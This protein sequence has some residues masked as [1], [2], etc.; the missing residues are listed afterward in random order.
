MLNIPLVASV[1]LGGCQREID[2]GLLA[3]C[4]PYSFLIGSSAAQRDKLARLSRPSSVA[5]TTDQLYVADT[6]NDR[7]L[8]FALPTSTGAAAQQVLMVSKPRSVAVTADG[9]FVLVGSGSG[10][11]VWDRSS[12][13]SDI[14]IATLVGAV[15][16]ES[17]NQPAASTAAGLVFI[18][19]S[20]NHRVFT[21]DSSDLPGLPHTITARLRMSRLGQRDVNGLTAN[22]GRGPGK[23]DANGFDNPTS[24]I[25]DTTLPG[26]LLYV[27]DTGNHRVGTYDLRGDADRDARVQIIKDEKNMELLQ[28]PRAL[29]VGGGALGFVDGSRVLLFS[30]PPLVAGRTRLLQAADAQVGGTSA[31]GPDPFTL[32]EPKGLAM[33]GSMLAVA[34]TDN[35]RV[36]LWS[37]WQERLPMPGAA[38]VALGQP[39]FDT[40]VPNNLG[41]QTRGLSAPQGL[42]GNGTVLVVCDTGNSRVLLYNPLP[43]QGPGPE[44]FLVLGQ[45]SAAAAQVPTTPNEITLA[46]PRGAF[47]GDESLLVA[48]TGNHRVLSF[49]DINGL[50]DT[51]RKAASGVLGQS[52]LRS[53]SAPT[54]PSAT[55]LH[56]PHG[57][58]HDGRSIYVAD[59]GHNRVLRFAGTVPGD[60][61]ET[62]NLVLGQPDFVS[63]TKVSVASS[64]SLSAPEAVAVSPGGALLVADTGN[65]RVLIW[66]NAASLSSG[67]SANAELPSPEAR[68][69]LSLELPN[70]IAFGADQA[71]YLADAGN[72]RVLRW[73]SLDAALAGAAPKVLDS[74]AT[75][76]SQP[77]FTDGS[78][79]QGLFVSARFLYVSDGINHRIAGIALPLR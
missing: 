11:V 34:D 76:F 28:T 26:S 39:G 57:V 10:V 61:G 72:H 7:V 17:F 4:E 60:K 13:R 38:Q 1:A 52:D 23:V 9:R 77:V 22:A 40:N 2:C 50:G 66:Y 32:R 47:L 79:P 41:N 42:T 18:V 78:V 74:R 21:F 68:A 64:S 37:G 54:T 14:S 19:D 49:R 16:G 44:P 55:R 8:I 62:A 27:T 3:R 36:L 20:T 33:N 70:A 65:N 12:P 59:T 53:G 58:V 71:L 48:D 15:S 30:K 24:A 46:S 43:L 69:G 35:H 5:L 29:A 67:A 45:A 31:Q 75:S 25:V 6:E 73:E 56:S 63:A 51:P